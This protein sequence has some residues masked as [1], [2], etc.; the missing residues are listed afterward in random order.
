MLDAKAFISKN[1]GRFR[2]NRRVALYFMIVLKIAISKTSVFAIDE[3]TISEREI[4]EKIH[5]ILSS[6]EFT[7]SGKQNG[8]LKSLADIIKGIIEWIKEKIYGLKLPDKMLPGGFDKM[9]PGKALAL[10]IS[11]IFIITAVVI[12]ILYLVFRNLRWSRRIK[13]KEDSVL[14]STLKD[15]QMVK[16]KA[17]EYYNAGDYK[18]ALR[19]LYISLILELNKLN[20]I[21]IDKSKTNKQ[22]LKEV[23]QSGFVK[24]EEFS[25]FT[26]AFNNHWYGNKVLN[27]EDFELWYEK[28][29]FILNKE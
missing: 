15:S 12:A 27:R 14:L 16:N 9:S 13:E 10:K 29:I 21:Y 8:L 1:N 4:E 28:Y 26:N 20:I 5:R 25:K 2:W 22:Y 24:Y 6:R 23:L 19:L 17:I 3:S 7:K 11:G 18:Q